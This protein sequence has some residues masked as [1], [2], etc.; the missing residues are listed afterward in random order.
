M[1]THLIKWEQVKKYLLTQRP[2]VTITLEDALKKAEQ[3]KLPANKIQSLLKSI[4]E[5][6]FSD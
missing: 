6:G 1:D 2:T 4:E 5:L 3:H